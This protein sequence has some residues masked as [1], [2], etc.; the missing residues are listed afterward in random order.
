MGEVEAESARF[1][2]RTGLVGVA[3]QNLAQSPVQHMGASV[4]LPNPLPTR[5]VDG[6]VRGLTDLYVAGGNFRSMPMEPLQS[7]PRVEDRQCS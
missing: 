1:D 2:Q 5:T 3:A 4:R 6:Q 7:M